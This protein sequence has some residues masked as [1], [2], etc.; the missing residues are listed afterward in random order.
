[1]EKQY[2]ICGLR[3]VVEEIEKEYKT[4]YAF[5]WDTGEF[6]ED[7]T[8]LRKISNDQSGET[9]KVSKEKFDDYVAK[10]KKERGIS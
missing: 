7:M 9:E 3:P 6:K 4:Y 1:M 8:Y 2:Y 10:L 5:Q